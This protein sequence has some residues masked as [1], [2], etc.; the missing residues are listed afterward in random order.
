[1]SIACA[2]CGHQFETSTE[3][4]PRL[5]CPTCGD[6]AR[7]I[8]VQVEDRMHMQD[9][10]Q[11]HGQRNGEDV[12]F[13]ESEL[14]GRASSARDEAGMLELDMRG[15]SPQGEEDTRPACVRLMQHLNQQGAD[16]TTLKSGSEPADYTLEGAS[17]SA[18]T[19]DVQVVRANAAQDIWRD[20]AATGQHTSVG[21][22]AQAVLTLREAIESK[23]QAARIPP[24]LRPSLI[25]ALDAR[26]TP[27]LAF[28]QVVREFRST[29][30]AWAAQQ[31]FRAI[32]VVGPLQQ[33]VSRL[34]VTT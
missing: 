3:T 12:F 10:V 4:V 22:I 5:P 6:G 32:W 23:A 17:G 2:K 31:G 20:L 24:A 18:Q 7:S 1:M 29:H 33:L 14:E 13:T 30:G 19:Q 27:H 9:Q 16:W 11:A 26:R 21:V 25:L 34:D 28:G 8:T 15:S